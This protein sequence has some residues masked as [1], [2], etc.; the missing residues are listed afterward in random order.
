MRCSCL[1]LNCTKLELRSSL[2]HP[3]AGGE[4]FRV[5]ASVW[6]GHTTCVFP[7]QLAV[8]LW[9]PRT[10]R[11]ESCGSSRMVSNLVPLI[12]VECGTTASGT[13]TRQVLQLKPRCLR[14]YATADTVLRHVQLSSVR[15]VD[16]LT[17]TTRFVETSHRT[18]D[19][20]DLELCITNACSKTA[21]TVQQDREDPWSSELGRPKIEE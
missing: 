4:V 5:P 7:S 10:I 6:F 15:P 19:S 16:T 18:A 17:V 21:S 13:N 9:G 3:R 20:I 8:R 12:V 1:P 2:P 11:R 14:T